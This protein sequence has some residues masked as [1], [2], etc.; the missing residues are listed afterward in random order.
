M[1]RLVGLF[2][3]WYKEKIV[4]GARACIGWEEYCFFFLTREINVTRNNMKKRG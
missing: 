4:H 2:G 3:R 1:M